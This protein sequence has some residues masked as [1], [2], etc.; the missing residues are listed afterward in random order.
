[1]FIQDNGIRMTRK[2][3]RALVFGLMEHNTLVIGIRI[4]KMVMVSRNGEM[5]TC[6]KVLLK[7][8]LCMV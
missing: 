4:R 1:V 5:V 8:V 2:K 6:M 7:M 3:V